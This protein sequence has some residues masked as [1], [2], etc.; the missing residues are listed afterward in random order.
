MKIGITEPREFLRPKDVKA[1][2]L[3]FIL[4]EGITREADF[5]TGKPRVVFEIE[6]EHNKVKKTW[7]TNKTT[8][9][10]FIKAWGDD[11]KKW[12]GKKAKL[13]LVKVNVR[14]EIKDSIIGVPTNEGDREEE[15]KVEVI[16]I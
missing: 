7:T 13:S 6:V 4:N 11:T 3:V 10:G 1:G 16:K 12:I 15:D 14:G 9:K 8:L 5:G 2:D